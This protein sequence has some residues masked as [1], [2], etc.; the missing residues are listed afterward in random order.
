MPSESETSQTLEAEVR[1]AT[2][3]LDQ[4]VAAI[5]AIGSRRG[6]SRDEIV[7]YLV[8]RDLMHPKIAKALVAK[9]LY[10]G[11]EQGLIKRPRGSHNYLV[12]MCNKKRP[13][14]DHHRNHRHHHH[15][16]RRQGERKSS[17]KLKRHSRRS[18]KHHRKQS[19]H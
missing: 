10:K 16:S 9:A 18:E 5:K 12:I 8:S 15:H 1:K 11:V 14:R 17:S 4:V 13:S 7:E 2:N 19:H 3:H 6:S